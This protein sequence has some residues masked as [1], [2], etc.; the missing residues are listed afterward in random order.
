MIHLQQCAELESTRNVG[1]QEL[2]LN[3]HNTIQQQHTC[4]T[5]KTPIQTL[6]PTLDTELLKPWTLDPTK[7]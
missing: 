3:K 2:A 5:Y 1:G 4:A 6:N 7:H